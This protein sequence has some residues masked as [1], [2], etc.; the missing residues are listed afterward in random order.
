MSAPK[1]Q[2]IEDAPFNMALMFYI[3]LNKLM[4]ARDR[5]CIMGDIRSWF[6]CSHRIYLRVRFK[7]NPDERKKFDGEI[8]RAKSSIS[9]NTRNN[10]LIAVQINN[11]VTNNVSDAL[12][13]FDSGLMETM[14]KYKMIFPRIEASGVAALLKRYGLEDGN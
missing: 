3:S 11:L 6:R 2:T 12:D 14:H 4:E 7:F 8:W 9:S 1:E 13:Q 10:G 5:A